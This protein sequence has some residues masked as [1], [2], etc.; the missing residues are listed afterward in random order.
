M[1]LCHNL[2]VRSQKHLPL[3]D[4]RKE[5]ETMVCLKNMNEGFISQVGDRGT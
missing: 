3:W 2:L 1:S 4:E 5:E